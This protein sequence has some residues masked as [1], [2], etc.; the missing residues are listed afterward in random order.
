MTN[1]PLQ[2]SRVP[3]AAAAIASVA[4]HAAGALVL[5][6]TDR[7]EPTPATV[8]DLTPPT[9]PQRTP[10]GIAR[11]DA[12]TLDW[13]GFEDPTPHTGELADANQAALDPS[14]ADA[15]VPQPQP[16]PQPSPPPTRQPSSQPETTPDPSEATDLPVRPA[17]P[18]DDAAVRTAPPEARP[19]AAA[20]A[21][22]AP[23]PAEPTRPSPQIQP[24]PP[25]PPVDAAPAEPSASDPA[26][27]DERQA[28]AVAKKPVDVSLNGRPIAR[29]GLQI[30]TVRPEF[31]ITS[32]L[33]LAP[34]NPVVTL[35]FGA[36]G[37]VYDHR[38]ERDPETEVELNTGS[39]RLDGPLLNALY[40]WRASGP[41]I[42]DLRTQPAEGDVPPTTSITVRI[43]LRR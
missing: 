17:E 40:R 24:M 26:I 36:D 10:L 31:S 7:H 18:G 27:P 39:A 32:Q 2:P 22:P 3:L 37:R 29:E 42:E 38:F 41:R 6:T 35:D 23:H 33:T 11:S 9:E 4:I 8:E 19:D 34:R 5:V 15:T 1:S 30:R 25:A 14:P 13:L 16:R 21:T 20:P 43:V 28:D 12:V